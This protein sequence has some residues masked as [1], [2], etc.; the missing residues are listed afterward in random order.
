MH[1]FLS[2]VSN[3]L[4]VRAKGMEPAEAGWLDACGGSCSSGFSIRDSHECGS[5]NHLHEMKHIMT[6]GR[7]E[8]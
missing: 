8:E 1:G 3:L 5:R 7:G 2:L 4:V 6:V